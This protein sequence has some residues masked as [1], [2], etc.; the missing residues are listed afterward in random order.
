M[1]RWYIENMLY[2]TGNLIS[3]IKQMWR[4]HMTQIKINQYYNAQT[5][6]EEFFV[7]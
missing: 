6:P 7:C 4:M 2:A 5:R 3:Q 1:F